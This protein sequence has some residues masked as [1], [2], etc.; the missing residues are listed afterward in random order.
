MFQTTAWARLSEIVYGFEL[1]PNKG[2]SQDFVFSKVCNEVGEYLV[3]PVFGDFITLT[4]K[5]CKDLAKL[6]ALEPE[7]PMRVKALSKKRPTISGFTVEDSGF[8]HELEFRSYTKWKSEQIK[9][10]FR[11]QVGQGARAGLTAL[12]SRKE[13]DIVKF[14]EMHAML[15]VTKFSEIPQPR[16]FFLEIF[17]SYFKADLGFML[18]GYDRQSRLIAGIIVLLDGDTAYYKFAA[19]APEALKL[20]PNN[21]LIA[22]LIA[23]LEEIGIKKINFGYTGSGAEYAGL[24]K[25]KLS[26][27]AIETPRYTLKTAP[28]ANLDMSSVVATNKGVADFLKTNPTLDQI[29]Q[30]SNQHYRNFA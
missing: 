30:F 4:Q 2:V 3:T 8:I 11:N 17:R 7:A 15:R 12:V 19:S 9:C 6:A 25:Y 13:E 5:D 28:F 16:E 14:W 24:R 26:T 10:K 22:E 23:Y 27:G 20:R 18:G 29:D 21:F 1:Q